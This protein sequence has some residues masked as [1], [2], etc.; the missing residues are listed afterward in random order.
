MKHKSILVLIFI[1]VAVAQLLVP[2]NMIY[3]KNNTMASGTLYK[4]KVQPIDPADPFIGRYV[5]LN[6]DQ[7]TFYTKDSKYYNENSI[8]YLEIERGV[9][10]F[11]IIK[12]I[13]LA[14]FDHTKDYITAKVNFVYEDRVHIQYPFSRFY[15]EETKAPGAE[16]YANTMLRDSMFIGF[17]EVFVYKGDAVLKD[18]KINN[19]TIRA[20]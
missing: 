10:S 11:A 2:A 3:Q 18:V 9:D 15:M 7:D 8:I 13:S 5:N 16:E 20:L 12:D 6:F 1:F 14:P 17:A 19:R 4:F